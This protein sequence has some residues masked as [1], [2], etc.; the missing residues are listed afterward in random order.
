MGAWG[1]GRPEDLRGAALS[2]YAFKQ[3]LGDAGGWVVGFGLMFFAYSTVIS[4]SYYGD[5]SAEYLFGERAVLPYRIIYT[6][7]VV[8]GAYVPL[9]LVWNFADI[10]NIF[11][12]APN[13]LSVILLAGL[14]KNLTDDYF[15]RS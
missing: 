9:K 2:A 4:W 10:A 13:L 15:R 14:T 12:A 11:M 5:R 3:A 1:E 8:V 6:V 7:L